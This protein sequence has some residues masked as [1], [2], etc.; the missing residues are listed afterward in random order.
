M[1]GLNSFICISKENNNAFP[2]SYERVQRLQSFGECSGV[3]KTKEFLL[4]SYPMRIPF[5]SQLFIFCLNQKPTWGKWG[6][7]PIAAPGHHYFL[8]HSICTV[9]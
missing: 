3:H 5:L 7:N 4:F 8:P 9:K 6:R 1:R 2:T